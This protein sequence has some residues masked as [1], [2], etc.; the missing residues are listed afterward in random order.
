[1]ETHTEQISGIGIIAD[2]WDA[3]HVKFRPYINSI[4]IRPPKPIDRGYYYKLYKNT[5]PLIR[6][7]LEENGFCESVNPKQQWLILWGVSTLKSK[8]YH[9][10][11]KYQKVNHFPRS[12]EITRKDCLCK[13]ISKMATIYGHHHFDF[14][15]RTFILPQELHLLT[16]AFEKDPSKFWIIKPSDSSQ[17]RGILV[18][19]DIADIPENTQCIASKYISNPLLID[20]YKFDLRIYLVITSINPLRLYVF[21]DGLARFATCKYSPPMTSNKGN[22]YIHLTNYSVNKHNKDFLFNESSTK[23][24]VGSKW[25]LKALMKYLEECGISSAML[26]E[27]IDEILIKTI[28]AIEP[29]IKSSCDMY[30]P[31]EGNC[32]ELLGFDILLDS[33]LTPW[34]LEVNLSPSLNCDSPLDQKIKGQLIADLFTLIGVV[35]LEQHD[36]SDAGYNNL[37]KFTP[38]R[39]SQR[40]LK[41]KKPKN[42]IAASTPI[43]EQKTAIKETNSEYRRRG[44]FRRIFPTI[45]YSYYKKFF[46]TERPLN[47]I[48]A[49]QLIKESP[50]GR[51]SQRKLVGK[52]ILEQLKASSARILK[53]PYLNK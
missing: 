28:L 34:L 32:F 50:N 45:H 33:A 31:Y 25:S 48:I 8:V 16:E 1:M 29:L 51:R 20:G 22:R 53:L 18:T 2:K 11:T 14:I 47:I 35:P 24:G 37:L 15:P 9:S 12:I 27:R 17:G 23:D 43:K 13:N 40:W 49:D 44:R 6:Y 39:K 26:W 10:L 19:N 46:E 7:T 30:V 42:Y 4:R 41:E 52:K 5:I 36:Y 3:D 38:I 21:E